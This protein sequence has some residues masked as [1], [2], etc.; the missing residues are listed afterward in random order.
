MLRLP[1]FTESAGNLTRRLLNPLEH[2]IQSQMFLNLKNRTK[3][4]HTHPFNELRDD[5]L[6]WCVHAD[7]F[8]IKHA[9]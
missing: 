9:K 8:I 3:G 5:A 6:T 7:T 1:Y 4:N 2:I